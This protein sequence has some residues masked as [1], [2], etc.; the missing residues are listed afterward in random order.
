MFVWE[1]INPANN[2]H[3]L[4]SRHPFKDFHPWNVE[5][6]NSS[7]KNNKDCPGPICHP[8]LPWLPCKSY[9]HCI[10]VNVVSV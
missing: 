4:G 7:R 1:K 2:H 5:E 8:Q 9:K 6:N 3:T 10:S